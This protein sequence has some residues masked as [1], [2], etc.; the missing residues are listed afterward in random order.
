[1]GVV[2]LINANTHY[3]LCGN[4]RQVV[5]H[6]KYQGLLF[7]A[8]TSG[9]KRINNTLTKAWKVLGLIKASLWNALVKVKKVA[10]LTLCRPVLEYA[11]DVWDPFPK[12]DIHKIEM[13]QN[14][15]IRFI[16]NLRGICSISEAKAV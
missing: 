3:T 11:S 16:L 14:K 2:H 6:I 4:V 1:M 5:D 12:K 13:L 15:A 7:L 9:K 8:L 10:Y